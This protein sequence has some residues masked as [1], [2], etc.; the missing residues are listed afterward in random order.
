[1]KPRIN[2]HYTIPYCPLT[3]FEFIPYTNTITVD[4]SCYYYRVMP[5]LPKVINILRSTPNSRQVVI[6]T[7][8]QFENDA[9]LISIQFLIV[10][11]KLIVIANF[12]SECRING[13]PNDERMLRY[14][15]TI[16]CWGLNLQKFKI[17]V[18]VAQYHENLGELNNFGLLK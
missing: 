12:R 6:V 8:K 1:M 11:K 9:C 5:Q 13:R 16:V 10:K 2:F 18:N 7:H 17:Y 4:E 14:F 3:S 15:A